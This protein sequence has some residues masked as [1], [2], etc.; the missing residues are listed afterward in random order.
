MK[1]VTRGFGAL[2]VSLFT[3]SLI[4]PVSVSAVNV[5]PG[6]G[7]NA[8]NTEVCKN[9]NNQPPTTDSSNPVLKILKTVINLLSYIIGIAAVIVILV[10]GLQMIISGDNPQT[11]ETARNMI[12]YALVGIVV[13]VLSQ[14]I[15]VYV[16]K[17]VP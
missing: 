2:I 3:F 9:I 13:A 8:A 1:R 12:L 17:N 16:L 15:V 5:F 14:T 4:I 6:C 7:S 10:A 11:V